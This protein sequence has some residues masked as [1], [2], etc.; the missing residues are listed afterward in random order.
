MGQDEDKNFNAIDELNRISGNA[1]SAPT[2]SGDIVINNNQAHKP[3]KKLLILIVVLVV[4]AVVLGAIAVF[5]NIQ[6]GNRTIESRV[7]D[8]NE[9]VPIK[10]DVKNYLSLLQNG[11]Q[12]S[13]Y[14]VEKDVYS[15]FTVKAISSDDISAEKKYQHALKMDVQY[16]KITAAIQSLGDSKSKEQLS[17]TLEKQ[18]NAF[19][20]TAEYLK[21]Q[22]I[23]DNVVADYLRNGYESANNMLVS[24][25]EPAKALN[26]DA[27]K[28]IYNKILKSRELSLRAVDVLNQSGCVIYGVVN[29]ECVNIL[30]KDPELGANFIKIENERSAI[31]NE[32][33]TVASN[34]ATA[35]CM[36]ASGMGNVLRDENK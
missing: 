19:R 20:V 26:N 7:I 11:D 33:Q 27:W 24:Y 5:M 17:S 36:S 8:S 3:K 15:W 31:N 29:E 4:I 10:N 35:F 16:N 12:D 22:S 23:I 25:N 14:D 6:K 21:N 2:G 1:F 9:L 34:Y 18:Q 13:K 30:Y 28:K 32:L